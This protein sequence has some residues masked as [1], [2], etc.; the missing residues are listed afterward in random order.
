MISQTAGGGYN[1][2]RTT[3]EGKSLLPHIGTAGDE[4]WLQWL[5]GRYCFELFKDL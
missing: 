5:W 1:N 4:N 2:V 3:R